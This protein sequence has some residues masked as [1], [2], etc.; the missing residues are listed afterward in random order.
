MQYLTCGS[1]VVQI[2][3]PTYIFTY[4]DLTNLTYFCLGK[5]K[6][7]FWLLDGN[8]YSTSLMGD[9]FFQVCFLCF[10]T[11]GSPSVWAIN[12]FYSGI[13]S[14]RIW[15]NIYLIWISNICITHLESVSK[16]YEILFL[17]LSEV[18]YKTYIWFDWILK[19]PHVW[20]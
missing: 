1:I 20:K 18:I 4:W 10:L 5:W 2:N 14:Y 19:M 7:S 16:H 9:I 12:K 3:L 17:H 11:S 6:A 8:I 15:P 13:G